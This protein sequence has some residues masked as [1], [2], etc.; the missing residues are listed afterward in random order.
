MGVMVEPRVENAVEDKSAVRTKCKGNVSSRNGNRFLIAFDR[1][2]AF[3]W[4][5]FDEEK[6]INVFSQAIGATESFHRM[7]DLNGKYLSYKNFENS[8]ESDY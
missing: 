7:C 5:V 4:R 3:T 8:L 1:D 6:I 2:Q